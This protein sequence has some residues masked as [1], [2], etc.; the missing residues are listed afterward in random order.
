MSYLFG[1]AF[2]N[3][4]IHIYNNYYTCPWELM[5]KLKINKNANSVFII[6]MSI[7]SSA[8]CFI[9]LTC[10]FNYCVSFDTFDACNIMLKI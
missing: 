2:L 8:N 9:T 1:F 4:V 3:I 6:S 7:L 5:T 10:L